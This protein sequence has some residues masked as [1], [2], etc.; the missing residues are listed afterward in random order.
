MINKL[1]DL[2]EICK[3]YEGLKYDPCKK[4]ITGI[5]SINK[6]YND[7]QVQKE[8]E[9]LIDLSKSYV[10]YVYDCNKVIKKLYPHMYEDRRLCLATDMEQYIYLNENKSICGWIKKYVEPYFFSYE[11]YR[12]YGTYPFG[13]YSHGFKGILEFYVEYY[14]LNDINE[15]RIKAVLNYIFLKRYRGHDLCPCGSL[16]KIRNCHKELILKAKDDKY[17]RYLSDCYIK[18]VKNEK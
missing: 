5:I 4:Q 7:E 3:Y 12:R 11:Y 14:N 9:I 8:Y 16:K 10:P 15:K 13:E 6:K 1:N 2:E 18:G 17:F